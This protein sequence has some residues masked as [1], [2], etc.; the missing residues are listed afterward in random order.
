MSCLDHARQGVL[1]TGDEPR[2]VPGGGQGGLV[3]GEVEGGWVRPE[4]D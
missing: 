4:V 3:G 1:V 2:A